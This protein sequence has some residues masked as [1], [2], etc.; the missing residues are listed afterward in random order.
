[1]TAKRCNELEAEQVR[2]IRSKALEMGYALELTLSAHL[3]FCTHHR[4][5]MSKIPK[6]TQRAATI[7][8]RAQAAGAM[9]AAEA[10]DDLAEPLKRKCVCPTKG[11]QPKVP[12]VQILKEK[13]NLHAEGVQ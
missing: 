10:K 5:F 9:A 3:F 4:L 7:S 2:A 11:V 12:A 1:M 8:A 6:A 13:K